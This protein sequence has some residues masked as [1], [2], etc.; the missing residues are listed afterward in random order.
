MK[1]NFIQPWQIGKNPSFYQSS[2]EHLIRQLSD[3]RQF[4]PKLTGFVQSESVEL[5]VFTFLSYVD[6]PKA[7]VTPDGDFGITP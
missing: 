1:L 3:A 5:K 4:S 6:K 7:F 2:R